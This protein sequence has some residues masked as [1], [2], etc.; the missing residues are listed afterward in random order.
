MSFISPAPRTLAAVLAAGAV[1]APA[2]S[3]ADRSDRDVRTP[4]SSR[5]TLG[6][7]ASELGLP[8]GA[9]RSALAIAG[10][11]RAA[12]RLG[13][14]RDELGRPRAL[15][16]GARDPAGVAHLRQ[17]VGGLR[18]LWSQVDVAVGAGRV[19]TVSGTLLPLRARRLAGA[20]RISRSE[21]VT[22]ARRRVKGPDVAGAAQLVAYAGDPGHPRVPRRAYVVSVDPAA[23]HGHDDSPA[24]RCVVIDARTG[25][26][27]TVWDGT[28]T[29]TAAPRSL[30]A[31]IA[32]GST[33]LAQYEDAKGR[34]SD[35]SVSSNLWDLRTNGD[36]FA[37]YD[38]TG[39]FFAKTGT[40]TDLNA[41]LPGSPPWLM[42][43]PIDTT[44]TIARFFCTQSR[45]FWCGRNGGRVGTLSPGYHRW[46]FT[47]NWDGPVSAFKPSQE[48]IYLKRGMASFDEQVHAHEM[49]H[50]ID[51]F[52]RDDYQSTFEGA[53][54]QEAL[55]EMFAFAYYRF[56]P[57]PD[58]QACSISQKMTGVGCS[59]L[60]H[61]YAGYSC[62]TGDVHANGYI[63]GSAFAQIANRIG[64][65]DAT[66][67]LREVPRLLPAKRT[68]GSV[69][70][71]FEDATTLQGMPQHQATV[72]DAFIAAGVTVAKRRTNACPG[73]GE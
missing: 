47:I 25:R 36:P 62:I 37:T 42:R 73:A 55:G 66:Q 16:R 63:L 48:R 22:I 56:R 45:M 35:A 69:H 72:H 5:V 6:E 34:T 24:A 10:V 3:A 32:A 20:V 65:D 57:S 28:V 53:E 54:V 38:T 49:G 31:R 23:P 27:L 4:W 2:A 13:I 26:V 44:T 50:V 43:R 41:I 9:P 30:G 70:Q 12:A 71:A 61:N 68:F 19:E 18:V 51:H 11:R 17:T 58:P 29:P 40:P 7:S 46:F 52:S 60:A 64:F 21:A 33:T 15:P 67:L 39:G 59:S 8:A 14:D 1:L